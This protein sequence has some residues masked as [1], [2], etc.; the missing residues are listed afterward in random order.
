M[1]YEYISIFNIF[2]SD[3]G[4]YYGIKATSSTFTSLSAQILAERAGYKVVH[5]Q[6]Y[7][8][9][10]NRDGTPIYPNIEAVDMKIMVKKLE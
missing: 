5:T 8:N 1:M 9:L 7:A 4:K 3:I 2:R 10:L 6:Y